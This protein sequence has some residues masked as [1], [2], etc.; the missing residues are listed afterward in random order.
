MLK[1][2][3]HKRF[4]KIMND[5]CLSRKC[6]WYAQHSVS[7]MPIGKGKDNKYLRPDHVRT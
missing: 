1:Q 2:K 7:T 3:E 6:H 4:T 5:T